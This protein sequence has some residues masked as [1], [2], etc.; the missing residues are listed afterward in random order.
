MIWASGLATIVAMMGIAVGLWVYSPSKPFRYG[1]EPSSIP[2]IGQK[3]WHSI[4]GLIFGVLACTWAF[5][6]MLSMV[7][8]P[9]VAEATQSE[10]FP[11]RFDEAIRGTTPSS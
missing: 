10:K 3:R 9:R 4:L 7:P 2:Y 8:F 1:G 6:G 5:S 11:P